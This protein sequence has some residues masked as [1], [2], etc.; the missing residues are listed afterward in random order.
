MIVDEY[1]DIAADAMSILDE[2]FEDSMTIMALPSKYRVRIRTSNMIERE[3]RELRR[4]ENVI[5]IFPNVESVIRLMG[6]VLMDDHNDW[7]TAQKVF[8]MGE[9]FD[10]LSKIQQKLR[11]VSA[12]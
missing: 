3:N 4:R 7:S 12:A 8:G 10:K 5:Q 1:S 6:G 9:Y 2:G 11:K